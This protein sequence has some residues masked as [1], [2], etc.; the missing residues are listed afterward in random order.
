MS[1]NIRYAKTSAVAYRRLIGNNLAYSYY[2][3]TKTVY[4]PK[5]FPVYHSEANKN[6]YLVWKFQDFSKKCFRNVKITT[7]QI[8]IYILKINLIKH[9]TLFSLDVRS[10]NVLL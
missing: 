7:I 6:F 9:V 1:S 2:F 8:K 4:R 10:A 5:H 3:V